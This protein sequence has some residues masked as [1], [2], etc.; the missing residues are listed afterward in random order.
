[1]NSE[2]ALQEWHA[3]LENADKIISALRV[4]S[5]D[6]TILPVVYNDSGATS[7]LHQNLSRESLQ[8]HF[9]GSRS[10]LR[11]LIE[12]LREIDADMGETWN[13]SFKLTL[14]HRLPHE[15]LRNIFLSAA[16]APAS[17]SEWPN[18]P[19]LNVS[20]QMFTTIYQV[21]R[22]W[23][24]VCRET[25]LFWSSIKFRPSGLRS[26]TPHVETPGFI[27][28][29]NG[30]ISLFFEGHLSQKISE[31]QTISAHTKAAFTRIESLTLQ[32]RSVFSLHS[33]INSISPLPFNYSMVRTLTLHLVRGY[34]LHAALF[35]HIK[36]EECKAT[37]RHLLRNF[38]C[39]SKL[40]VIGPVHVDWSMAGECWSS[41]TVLKL[42]DITI[43]PPKEFI[44]ALTFCPKLQELRLADCQAFGSAT[45]DAALPE[46][47][48]L[49]DLT[50]IACGKVG[51]SGMKVLFDS[52]RAPALNA[53]FIGSADS[54]MA[55]DGLVSF[56]KGSGCAPQVAE[57]YSWAVV[58][59]E[60][61]EVPDETP[62][63]QLL[64]LQ[65]LPSVKRLRIMWSHVA[66]DVLDALTAANE[67]EG[68]MSSCACP[69]L[70]ELEIGSE[71]YCTVERICAM[72]ELRKSR[73]DKGISR[74]LVTLHH[75]ARP[76]LATNAY[77]RQDVTFF[78]DEEGTRIVSEW[79]G[80]G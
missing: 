74:P 59:D 27:Y 1:M 8:A 17:S 37:V 57:M 54:L 60:F 2:S 36:D 52:I 61:E 13:R 25:T 16:L 50:L 32:G 79:L 28:T 69:V 53:I 19:Y 31:P 71:G 21:C 33:L 4:A 68:T 7:S 42:D 67:G 44:V 6:R 24:D 47:F 35:P 73:K 20:S 23:R 22:L 64:F 43:T 38:T 39:L 51:G 48:T 30:P 63:P 72:L 58:M 18:E 34:H 76:D 49:P 55:V 70:G 66:R 12:K 78:P 40:H 26:L 15:L 56:I 14:I 62:S 77:Q 3:K 80:R 45:A 5:Q 75:Y 65:V 10:S 9:E 29:K 46:P 11:E 41:L